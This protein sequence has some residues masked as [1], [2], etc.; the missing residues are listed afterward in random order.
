MN[1]LNL[2]WRV[3]EHRSSSARNFREIKKEKKKRK[4]DRKSLRRSGKTVFIGKI[5]RSGRIKEKYT[6]AD[7][8]D[9][10]TRLAKI[11]MRE[12]H[13]VQVFNF[14]GLPD[15]IAEGL[16]TRMLMEHRDDQGQSVFTSRAWRWLFDIRGPLVHELI[17]EFFSTFR[18]G[19]EAYE[20]ER[21][22]FGLGITFSRGDADYWYTPS[23]TLIRVPMLRLCHRMIV[24]SIV[25]RSQA[26]EKVTVTD[27]FYLRG[28][29]VGSINFV[30]RLAKHFG[31]FTE[32]RLWGLTVI[33]QDLHVIDMAEL[34]RLH[35]CVKLDDTWAWVPTGPARQE[36]DVGGVAEEDLVALG[37]GDE[38]EEIPQAVP[39]PP[40]TQG[41]RIAR[42]EEEVHGSLHGLSLA[43]HGLM[44]RA[45]YLSRDIQR[46]PVRDTRD[47][48]RTGTTDLQRS[49]STPLQQ[50]N[51]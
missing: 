1:V 45:M 7:T 31:L 27:L 48:Q 18:F 47:A 5:W 35:I 26:P 4:E 21:V 43:S 41:E 13:R 17:L 39:P 15:L 14:G 50:P 32:E 42:L 10:E 37:G 11:Y 40:R 29:D 33:V 19:E 44:D 24:C 36:G 51:P 25:G 8:S 3:L 49:T 46:A 16:S 6:N 23:Y 9:F 34:V 12:V 2:L 20:L 30:A 22:Y 38:D 28:M